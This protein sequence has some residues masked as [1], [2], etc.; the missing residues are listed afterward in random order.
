MPA[1]LRPHSPEWFEAMY[2]SRPDEA[3]HTSWILR[4]AG[5][6][7]ACGNCG[8]RFAADVRLVD[9]ADLPRDAVVTRRLCETCI[10]LKADAGEVFVPF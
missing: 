7:A 8:S 10:K 2:I 1:F 9:D 6:D 5:L 4:I 3:A